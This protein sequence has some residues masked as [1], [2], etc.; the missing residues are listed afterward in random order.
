VQVQ[1]LPD[2]LGPVRRL[3][4][5]PVFQAGQ[6]GSKPARATFRGQKSEVRDQKSEL[7]VLA[8]DLWLLTSDFWNG[9]VVERQTREAQNLVPTGRE[10]SNPSL[11]TLG[12][13]AETADAA[14]SKAA[15]RRREGS[16]P[17]S[18]TPG[19]SNR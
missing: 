18:A 8:S 15:A 7:A 5:P 11:A 16:I 9:Q 19:S 14:V 2:A 3:V 6:A 17:S 13:V 1:L 12:R 4:M 10:G